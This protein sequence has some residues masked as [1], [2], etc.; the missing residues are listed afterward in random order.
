MIV[1]NKSLSRRTVLR[2]VGVTL[3]LPFLDAMVPALG[4]SAK[5]RA[6]PKIRL[7]AIEMAHGA[8][9]STEIGRTKNYWSPAQIGHGFEFTRSLEALEPLRGYVTVIS[10]TEHRNASSL[11]DSEDGMMADHA[12]SSAVFLTG[13]H[14]KRTTD[15]DIEAGP[16]FDQLYAQHVGH[17][18]SVPSIQL[19][20]EDAVSLSGN[21][22]HQ[23]SCAYTNTISWASANRPLPME[24]TPRAVFDLL[25][26]RRATTLGQSGSILDEMTDPITQLGNS[27][28]PRDRAILIEYVEAIRETERRIQETEKRNQAERSARSSV[29]DSFEEHVRLM[30][31]LQVLAFSGDI[32]RVSAFKMGTDRSPRIYPASGVTT[33]FHTLSHHREE[34]ERIA[35]FARLNQYH[36]SKVA[37]F[38]E[39]LRN[40]PD[41]GGNL[42][43]HAVVLYGSPMGDSHVH[44]HT[45]LPLFLAGKACGVLAG[46]LHLRCPP[47]TP[48]ANVLLSLLRK[49][50]VDQERI[51]DSTGTVAI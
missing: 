38:L 5:A 23:Y 10:D 45:N 40:T 24:R 18:T 50:G 7:A 20:M 3:A 47:G 8:A 9:G 29:P 43:D 19:C 16:S 1:R 21:C 12:R 35:E 6:T 31:D 44:G 41:G 13:A 37:Y 15:T 26:Q 39:R 22:G 17:E 32:T 25:F 48:M 30:F 11:I 27:V 42:L 28:G 36:V 51:G 33:E 2:G 14:P 34:P 49:L 46:N 4:A